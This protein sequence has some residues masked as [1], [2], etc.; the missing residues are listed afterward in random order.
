MATQQFKFKQDELKST[1]EK[2]AISFF[3]GEKT[4]KDES[5]FIQA[6]ASATEI[7]KTSQQANLSEALINYED[8]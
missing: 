7:Y 8:K 4:Y 2:W 3:K 6:L 5:I 1:A